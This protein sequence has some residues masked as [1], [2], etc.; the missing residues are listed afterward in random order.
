MIPPE[1]VRLVFYS[2]EAVGCRPHD[3]SP[4][5]PAR[6]AQPGATAHSE[7]RVYWHVPPEVVALA[8]QVRMGEVASFDK[9]AETFADYVLAHVGVAFADP[10]PLACA[11]GAPACDSCLAGARLP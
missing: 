9:A 4:L 8:W 6:E 2:N 11:H 10:A 1:Q 5:R 7:E 3:A